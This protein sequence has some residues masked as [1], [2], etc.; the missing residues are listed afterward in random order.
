MECVLEALSEHEA[1]NC[2]QKYQD[3]SETTFIGLMQYQNEIESVASLNDSH[4]DHRHQDQELSVEAKIIE[5]SIASYIQ[6]PE[7]SK[8]IA[9]LSQTNEDDLIDQIILDEM[10]RRD[11]RD[12]LRSS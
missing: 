9:I 4:R 7:G 11:D 8:A 5:Q 12:L 2:N 10:L 6:R 3:V 1:I